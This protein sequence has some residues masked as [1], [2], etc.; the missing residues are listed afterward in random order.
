LSFLRIL[1]EQIFDKML[2]VSALY[3]HWGNVSYMEN[4]LAPRLH[5]L[6]DL[7]L[8]SSDYRLHALQ[9]CGLGGDGPSLGGPVCLLNEDDVSSFKRQSPCTSDSMQSTVRGPSS[10]RGPPSAFSPPLALPPLVPPPLGPSS[11]LPSLPLPAPTT[12]AP[13]KPYIADGTRRGEDGWRAQARTPSSGTCALQKLSGLLVH[14]TAEPRLEHVDQ[15]D[16]ARSG[17][18]RFFPTVS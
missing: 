14:N 4:V 17:S 15:L 9:G 10:L 7:S 18:L 1:A 2:V 8:Q 13:P 12:P 6:L 3:Y 16:H 11:L 5:A